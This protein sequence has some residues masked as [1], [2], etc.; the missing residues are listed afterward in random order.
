MLMAEAMIEAKVVLAVEV[1]LVDILVE[2]AKIVGSPTPVIKMFITSIT[3]I[4]P[5]MSKISITKIISITSEMSIMS[6][7][8][9][10]SMEVHN[11]V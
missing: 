6:I 5:I 3:S 8:S 10:M 7:T 2:A 1:P 11:W 4:K 9:T